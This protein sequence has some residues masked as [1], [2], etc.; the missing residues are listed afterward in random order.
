MTENKLNLE[1]NG[2]TVYHSLQWAF[3]ILNVY[4]GINA[5]QAPDLSFRKH[6]W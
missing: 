4:S 3:K 5:L 2:I 6:V 1:Q